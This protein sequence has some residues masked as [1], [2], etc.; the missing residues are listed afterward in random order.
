[1]NI[2]IRTSADIFRDTGEVILNII[3]ECQEHRIRKPVL[4]KQS[5]KTHILL[6]NCD[7]QNL[8]VWNRVATHNPKQSWQSRNDSASLPS[9]CLQMCQGKSTEGRT[10]SSR[11]SSPWATHYR[12]RKTYIIYSYCTKGKKSKWIKD[13]I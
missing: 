7:D 11:N 2:S 4:K 8:W 3:R 1:M 5:L 12:I 13:L 9:Q 6:D 10:A